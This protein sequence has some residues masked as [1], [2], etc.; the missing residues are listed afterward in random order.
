MNNRITSKQVLGICIFVAIFTIPMI[1]YVY[2]DKT[3]YERIQQEYIEKKRVVGVNDY[4]TIAISNN[5]LATIY[6]TEYLNLLRSNP[7]EAY[8]KLS[9]E[10]KKQKFKNYNDFLSYSLTI[11]YSNVI[12]NITT[13][14]TKEGYT[15][16]IYDENQN[17]ISITA[18]AVMN[19]TVKIN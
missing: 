2:F 15:Y 4:S 8:N 17:S 13:L 5:K 3:S 6:Y 19:Y 10:N 1:I 16:T 7:K 11:P 18:T 12:K 9:K 14:E